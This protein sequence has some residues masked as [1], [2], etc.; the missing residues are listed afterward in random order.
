MPKPRSKDGRQSVWDYPRPPALE[1][2]ARRVR[3][4]FGEATIAE[5]LDA[6]CVLETSH[7]PV[8]YIPPQD[9]REGVLIATD[10]RT[11]C[12][13]KG[14][15]RYYHVMVDDFVAENAAWSYPQPTAAYERIRDYV[16][17]YAHLMDACYVDD[18]RVQ[19]QL[20]GFYGGWITS[21][22][23]GPFKGQPGTEGW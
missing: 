16:A 9:I 1:D 2:C 19:S 22:I 15:A 3:V 10:R 4:V 7:P 13:F 23:E 21:D 6:K 14:V 11:F 8:Y 17:F 18:Q 20:G 12:E 5:S